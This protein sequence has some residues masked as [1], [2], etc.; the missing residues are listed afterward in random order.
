MEKTDFAE[1]IQL[2]PKSN[3]KMFSLISMFIILS[4]LKVT[5]VLYPQLSRY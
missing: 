3:V 5:S 4:N 1:K 2:V